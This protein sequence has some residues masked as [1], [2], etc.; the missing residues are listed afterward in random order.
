M[1]VRRSG[2][3]DS[4]VSNSYKSSRRQKSSTIIQDEFFK[5][6]K[7]KSTASFL[8]IWGLTVL[9]FWLL[10]RSV[11][12]SF[13]PF[14]NVAHCG[15]SKYMRNAPVD[16]D[17]SS[18]LSRALG[19]AVHHFNCATYINRRRTDLIWFFFRAWIPRV[20]I[21]QHKD[22]PRRQRRTFGVWLGRNE[23]DASSC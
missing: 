5:W 8:S 14:G 23:L 2:Q 12:L 22:H 20:L 15:R 11:N 9:N 3:P 10:H 1:Q 18:R 17:M 21:S 6:V 19:P 4:A 7:Q 16:R 13:F